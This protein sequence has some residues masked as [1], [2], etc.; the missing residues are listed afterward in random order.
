MKKRSRDDP[1]DYKNEAQAKGAAAVD[2]AVPSHCL[3]HSS[4]TEPIKDAL[5]EEAPPTRLSDEQVKHF[6]D[7][8]WVAGVPVLSAEAVAKLRADTDA[9]AAG[10]E[11]RGL[12]YEFHSN[13]SGDP[14]NVLLHAL[15]QWRMTPAF[16]ALAYHPPI[17]AAASQ[18]LNNRPIRL[19]HDQLFCKP[20]KVGG[21]VAW[22]QDY[23]YWTRTVP[24][25][26]IT[27]HIALDEQTAENGPLSFISGSHKWKRADGKD[28]PLP[29]T[30]AN[31]GDMESIYSVL[32][33]EQRKA[34]DTPTSL[35]LKPGEASFHHG[36][37]VHGSQPNRSDNQRRATVLNYF[38]D[39]TRSATDEPLLSGVPAVPSG[40]RIC[41]RFFPRVFGEAV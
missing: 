37:T 17:V 3:D 35:R 2:V 20:A 28:G 21:G 41:G 36:L 1:E 27:V 29:I 15:G 38:V 18:L 23:S 33:E 11:A 12:L 19:F 22:H 14:S 10:H 40:Q 26:H 4:L 31:F 6:E 32:S 25:Q 24:M 13:Q 9:I 7:H 8:G 39:G 16:H 34:F 30:D 5:G